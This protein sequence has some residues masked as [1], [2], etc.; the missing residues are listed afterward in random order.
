MKTLHPHLSRSQIILT[1]KGGAIVLTALAF[2]WQDLTILAKEALQS[3]FTTHIL[4]IPFLFT[5]LLY[6][7]RKML[8]AAIPFKTTETKPHKTIFSSLAIGAILCLL[9]ILVYWYGSYTFIPLEYHVVSLIIFVIGCVLIMF[10]T[11]TLRVIAFPVAFLLFLVPPPLQIV[12]AL[13]STMSTTSSQAAHA[14]LETLGLPVSLAEQYETPVIILEKSNSSPLT[15]AVDIACSG[16]YSLIGF[17]IF[18]VFVAYISKG[19]AWKKAA[20]FLIGFP[21]IYTLNILRITTIVLIGNQYGMEPAMQ[22]FHLLGG[23]VLIFLG[24]LFLLTV[25]EKILKTQ[26]FTRKTK[27]NPCPRC[28][29]QK[30]ENRSFCIACGALLK[31]PE[32][33]IRK[34][35]LAKVMVL[36]ATVIL[37][38][39]IQAPVFAL[40][41]GPAEVILQTPAGQQVT[42]TIL[43]EMPGYTSR[44][45]HRDTRFEQIAKQDAALT[46]AYTSTSNNPETIWVTIEVAKS[47]SNLHSWEGCLISY[48][49]GLGRQPDVTQLDLRDVELLQNPP[50]I[51]R[52][53]AFQQKE[54]N[55][56]QVVLYWYENARFQTNTTSQQ[57]YVKLSLITFLENPARIPESEDSLLPF[58]NAIANH[59]Q[60]IKTWSQISLTISQNGALLIAATT[61]I[62]AA[63]L[64]YQTLQNWQTKRSNQKAY[65]KLSETAQQILQAVHKTQ[66][67]QNSTT[68]QIAETYQQLTGKPIQLDVLHQKLTNAKE[69][70]LT[71][72]T[73]TNKNDHPVLMWRTNVSL[74]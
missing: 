50:L 61:T 23:W 27:A 44:F 20:T 4:A 19:R 47:K 66:N 22:A 56:T 34:Q 72:Q 3:E 73:I 35:D 1:M 18:A 69:I 55:R 54:P 5:Y 53:F 40:T 63:L 46:Y 25:S 65:Q 39:S 59:W 16:I 2:Y 28:T 68:N 14:I 17:L 45:V 62:L 37:L 32:I 10:N 70:G 29:S 43:P 49:L 21:L 15:F 60:P 38:L 52:Y 71:K 7:K 64:T 74:P 33:T 42:T 6:R 36:F 9:A 51:G 67:N 12:Y 57:E 13:G 58:A 48:P 30:Q 24:T 41:Q 31:T 26:I 8:K 11:L